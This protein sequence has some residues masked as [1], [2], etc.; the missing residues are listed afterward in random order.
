[1][2]TPGI[3]SIWVYPLLCF[4]VDYGFS[5]QSWKK[6]KK[7]QPCMCATARAEGKGL[8]TMIWWLVR[9]QVAKSR[10][11][12]VATNMWLFELFGQKWFIAQCYI[13]IK[14]L[15]FSKNKV[16]S[17]TLTVTCKNWGIYLCL[18]DAHTQPVSVYILLEERRVGFLN[19]SFNQSW[20]VFNR[21]LYA[22][23]ASLYNKTCVLSVI[24]SWKCLFFLEGLK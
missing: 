2:H 5:I 1:M 20:N 16:F 18:E 21:M 10:A 15:V 7:K 24:K 4:G 17:T 22:V 11:E 9:G 13:C 3:G 12:D 8:N 14:K 23:F 19:T 6:R